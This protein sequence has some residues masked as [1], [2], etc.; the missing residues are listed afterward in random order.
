MKKKKPI[1][2]LGDANLC[3]NKWYEET[4]P[5]RPIAAELQG[6][7]ATCELTVAPLGLTYT[8]DRLSPDGNLIQSALDHI[9]F[10]ASLSEKIKCS[11]LD[12]QA[13]DHVPIKT[14]LGSLH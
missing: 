1:V 4:Y 12:V 14:K 3:S 11:K 8:A 9:Y 10:S 6:A 2:A 5:L 7:L 13:T